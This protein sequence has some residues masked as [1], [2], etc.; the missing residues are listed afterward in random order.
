MCEQSTRL[1]SV[2]SS[3]AEWIST[4]PSPVSVRDAFACESHEIIEKLRTETVKHE[5]VSFSINGFTG[6]SF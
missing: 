3:R 5:K 1:L 4:I 2:T 6:A